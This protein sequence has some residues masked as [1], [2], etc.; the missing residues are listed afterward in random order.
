M[1]NIIIYKES[2][3]YSFSV[4]KKSSTEQTISLVI[5]THK[6]NNNLVYIHFNI[7]TLDRMQRWISECARKDIQ[8]NIEPHSNTSMVATQLSEYFF[9]KRTHFDCPVMFL[10]GTAL[11][12]KVWKYLLTIPVGQTRSYSEVAHA[13]KHS[14]SVRTVA[15]AIANNPIPIVVPCHRVIRKD[16]SLGQYQ[17]GTKV[18]KAFLDL[19]I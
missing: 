17:Y 6:N 15:S 3:S 4:D 5:Y 12:K 1:N 9:R 10:W 8:V 19:E 13:V 16:K 18:K 14:K 2:C 7:L 11:Q